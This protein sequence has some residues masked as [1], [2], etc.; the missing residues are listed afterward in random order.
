[1]NRRDALGDGARAGIPKLVLLVMGAVFIGLARLLPPAGQEA[2]GAAAGAGGGKNDKRQGRGRQIV[3]A[4]NVCSKAWRSA[5][6]R[7]RAGLVTAGAGEY[8]KSSRPGARFA[9]HAFPG[10]GRHGAS[11]HHPDQSSLGTHKY[12]LLLRGHP[13]ATVKFLQSTHGDG[14]RQG[15]A[16]AAGTRNHRAGF[17]YARDLIP[18]TERKEAERA[19]YS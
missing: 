7:D 11:H 9:A 3:R 1:M 4:R 14:T 15:P 18:E 6:A 12:Q 16:R 2:Q 10:D 8:A 19:G 5:D 13:L 17:R